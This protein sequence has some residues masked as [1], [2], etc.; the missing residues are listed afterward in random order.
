M[1]TGRPVSTSQFELVVNLQ[2]RQD[3][4]PDDPAV[5]S[6]AGGSGDRVSRP[7][8]P[9][10]AGQKAEPA[11]KGMRKALP[12]EMARDAIAHAEEAPGGRV[13]MTFRVVLPR[14]VAEGRARHPEEKNIAM[15]VTE[16]LEAAFRKDRT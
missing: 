15:L 10:P 1:T 12:A 6:A 16:L 14:Q 7:R 11:K 13:R 2:D 8:K 3:P 4:R 5:V 9:V